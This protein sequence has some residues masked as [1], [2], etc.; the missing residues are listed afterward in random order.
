MGCSVA[1]R[2]AIMGSVQLRPKRTWAGRRGWSVQGPWHVPLAPCPLFPCSSCG[3]SWP[4]CARS[5]SQAA[6]R[7]EAN[8]LPLC[9]DAR[10]E[11]PMGPL[12][13]AW[14]PR[15]PLESLQLGHPLLHGA[16]CD[17]QHRWVLVIPPRKVAFSSAS[18]W[19][20]RWWRKAGPRGAWQ[21]GQVSFPW[22]CICCWRH[23]AK[24]QGMMARKA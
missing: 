16:S 14:Q 10:P 1:M 15:L 11:L 24:A 3:A 21:Q 12:G 7:W 6:G 23:R 9:T 22:Y 2:V 18:A 5:G 17:I 20:T 8:P 4:S 19:E 13:L